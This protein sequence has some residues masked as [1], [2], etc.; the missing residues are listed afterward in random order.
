MPCNPADIKSKQLTIRWSDGSG[1]SPADDGT[2]PLPDNTAYYESPDLKLSGGVDE[3]TAKVGVPNTVWAHVTNNGAEA[4]TG[5]NIEVWV[6]NFVLGIN[7]ASAL[8]S[9]NPGGAA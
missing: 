8:A 4:V 5:V 9:S 2:R 7:P 6:C 1:G 3:G